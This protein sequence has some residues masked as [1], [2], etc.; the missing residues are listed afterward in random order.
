MRNAK[1]VLQSKL[2]S[3]EIRSFAE[4]KEYVQSHGWTVA[5]NSETYISVD[6]AGQRARF[7]F[8]FT[9]ES[10]FSGRQERKAKKEAERT[11][12]RN[13]KDAARMARQADGYWIY[14]LLACSNN[15]KAVYI[16]QT[17]NYIKRFGS[18]LAR[19]KHGRGSTGLFEWADSQG[20]TVKTV[21]LDFVQ[22]G[23][24][25]EHQSSLATTTEG[26]WL[27]RALAAGY[28]APLIEHWGRLP[29]ISGVDN[30]KWP[31]LEIQTVSL[32]VLEVKTKDL[33]PE[34]FAI[35]SALIN[36]GL[37]RHTTSDLELAH[38]RWFHRQVQTG[39]NSANAGNLISSSEVECKFS[40]KRAETRRKIAASSGANRPSI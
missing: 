30:S 15:G 28:I 18:H 11:K 34:A 31:E 14:A 39:L 7:H 27:Q 24:D 10:Y 3:G 1:Y 37:P 38:D 16:G 19:N 8:S 33:P 13:E 36:A 9:N 32:P 35:Q 26:L 4:L 2:D 29:K 6:I 17:T 22:K 12:A 40:A 25:G 5:R 21:L 23:L 20:V